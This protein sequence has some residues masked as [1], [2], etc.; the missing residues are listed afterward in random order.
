MWMSC[1]QSYPG[2]NAHNPQEFLRMRPRYSTRHPSHH[3]ELGHAG[4]DSSG[5]SYNGFWS[6]HPIMKKLS[7]ST[8]TTMDKGTH[9]FIGMSDPSND[10]VSLSSHSPTELPGNIPADEGE[11]FPLFLLEYTLVQWNC[12][13]THRY[14]HFY[15]WRWCIWSN[16]STG[17]DCQWIMAS[18]EYHAQL[19]WYLHK[20]PFHMDCLN[21]A[22]PRCYPPHL[23]S[24][25]FW[26][27]CAYFTVH[28]P[29]LYNPSNH[30]TRES[31][32]PYTTNCLQK[33]PTTQTIPYSPCMWIL[34]MYLQP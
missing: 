7:I 3:P 6:Q 17:W 8:W 22:N 2:T 4:T 32:V 33:F 5:Q 13:N 34:C 16:V 29:Y 24:S 11:W 21:C 30:P 28:K 27:V 18:Q 31:Y 12:S 23:L 10:E 9:Q 20:Q 15:Q 19:P 1:S 25:P 14:D 26:R